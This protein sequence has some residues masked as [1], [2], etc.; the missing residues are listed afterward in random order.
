MFEKLTKIKDATEEAL[1]QAANRIKD[2][3]GEALEE[4][5]TANPEIGRVR[6]VQ[7][8][9]HFND[10]DACVFSVHTVYFEIKGVGRE[11]GPKRPIDSSNILDDEEDDDEWDD[12]L[13]HFESYEGKSLSED[14][15]GYRDHPLRD[16]AGRTLRR[17]TYLA[18]YALGELMDSEGMSD[19]MQRAFGDGVEVIA[20]NTDGKVTFV[21]N[22]YEHD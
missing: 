13:N 5:F 2:A 4:F 7:Y 10:G 1:S 15:K 20:K 18:A 14:G 11:G 16:A 8:T 21:V 19:G 3:L 22:D 9:P 12:G 17:E 6:W